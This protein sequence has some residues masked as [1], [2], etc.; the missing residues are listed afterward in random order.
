[1]KIH[2][3]ISKDRFAKMILINLKVKKIK[4]STHSTR[5]MCVQIWQGT[6]YGGDKSLQVRL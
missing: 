4:C 3:L 2:L 5:T 6:A 1:M